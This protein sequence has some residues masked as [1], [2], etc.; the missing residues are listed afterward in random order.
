[1]QLQVFGNGVLPRLFRPKREEIAAGFTKL[2]GK[3]LHNMYSSPSR[4]NKLRR[5][6]WVRH[7]ACMG[8][9]RIVH[10]VLI[11]KPEGKILI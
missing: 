9:M 8:K 11:R 2:H 4:M 3:R 5:M 1:M 7:V 6:R 10:E